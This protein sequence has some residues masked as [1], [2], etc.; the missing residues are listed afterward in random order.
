MEKVF[1]QML[2]DFKKYSTIVKNWILIEGLL[3]GPKLGCSVGSSVGHKEGVIVGVL[4]GRSASKEMP[5]MR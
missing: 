4:E 3:D 2:Y 5:I 1:L